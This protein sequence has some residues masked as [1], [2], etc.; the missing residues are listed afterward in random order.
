MIK[1]RH[2]RINKKLYAKLSVN[3]SSCMGIIHNVSEGGL[4]VCSSKEFHKGST[5]DIE[6][7][8]PDSEVSFLKGLVKRNQ[9]MP[10]S[11][12]KHGLGIE[13]IKKDTKYMF[14]IKKLL[15]MKRT[16]HSH[17]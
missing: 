7:F 9:E 8:M 16:T 11:E 13:L 3:S 12:R 5:I 14:F 10:D 15:A 4:F 17:N 1:R 6:I 2:E